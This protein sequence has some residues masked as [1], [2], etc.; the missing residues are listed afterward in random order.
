MPRLTLAHSPDPDDAFMWW[1]LAGAG[2]GAGGRIDRGGFEFE[3]ILNDIQSLNDAALR[4]EY[5]IIAISCAQYPFVAE[6][7]AITSCG[8]SF[9]EGYGP[10]LVAGR[11]MTVEQMREADFPIA[12]PGLRTTAA[13]L[14]C[15]VLNCPISRLRPVSFETVADRV[16]GGEFEAGIVIHEGQLTFAGQGLHLV[17][18]VGAWWFGRTQLPLP[19]GLNVIKRDLEER[20]GPGA[21]R[22]ISAVLR[23]SIDHAMEH[24]AAAT[25]AAMPYARGI[26]LEQ[27]DQFIRMYVNRWT[28]DCGAEGRRAIEL[29]LREG[30]GAGALPPCGVVDVVSPPG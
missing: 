1:A 26:T 16:A 23:R 5:D 12:V 9:G 29:L 8:A 18:D 21:L 28:L 14:T 13:L 3:I 15:M 27:A 6:R 19:L 11:S 20:V 30:Y 22:R 17:Q 24:R 25:K 7:Y 2:S 10:K 4:S